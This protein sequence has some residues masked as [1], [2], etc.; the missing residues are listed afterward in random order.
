M[1][2]QNYRRRPNPNGPAPR[3][4]PQ[5]RRRLPGLRIIGTLLVTGGAGTGDPP[6]SRKAAEYGDRQY[7]CQFAALGEHYPLGPAMPVGRT[8]IG[9]NGFGPAVFAV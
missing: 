6:S 8:G 7:P 2:T 1:A 4:R 3:S 5:Y 9:G